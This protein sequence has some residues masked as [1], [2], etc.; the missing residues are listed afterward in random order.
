MLQN[1]KYQVYNTYRKEFPQAYYLFV[2]SPEQT[3]LWVDPGINTG[4]QSS[5]HPVYTR[6]QPQHMSGQRQISVVSH[7]DPVICNIKHLVVLEVLQGRRL[8]FSL[9]LS[10]F[11]SFLHCTPYLL[12]ASLYLSLITGN[13][14]FLLFQYYVTVY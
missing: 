2:W 5:L 13:L 12:H 8:F 4:S 10:S 7:I 11:P 6:E 9:S 3:V 14:D 1:S